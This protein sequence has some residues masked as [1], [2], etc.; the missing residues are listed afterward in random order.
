MASPQLNI[1]KTVT[2]AVTTTNDVIYTAPTGYTG[3]ILMAHIANISSTPATVTF[4]T[5]NGV[6][7]TELLKDFAIPGNDASAGV[8]GKLI[9]ETGNSVKI[10][11]SANNKFKVTLSVLESANE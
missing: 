11:A 5:D 3:I 10:Q 6:S 8:T 2:Y 1:F 4:A 7:E 9:L